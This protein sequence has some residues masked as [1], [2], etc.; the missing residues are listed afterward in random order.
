MANFIYVT[1]TE[2]YGKLKKLLDMNVK[3]GTDIKAQYFCIYAKS[4]I[5]ALKIYS[6]WFVN[7][8]NWGITDVEVLYKLGI[9]AITP[10][11][12]AMKE[13]KTSLKQQRLQY[14]TLWPE[15]SNKLNKV[16]KSGYNAGTLYARPGFYKQKVWHYDLNAAFAEAFLKA[17]IPVGIPEIIKG[18]VKPDGKHLHV[19][20][21]D[22]N[23]EYNS[24]TIFPYLVNSGDIN[25]VPSQI[26]DNTGYQSLYKVITEVEFED[27]KKDYKVYSNCLY[28]I[29]FKKASEIIRREGSIFL[30]FV[31][32]MYMLRHSHEGEAKVVYKTVLASLAGKFAQAIDQLQVPTMV[33]EFGNIEYETLKKD[34]E[35]V[36]YLHPAISLFV[37]DYVR[38]KV[39]DTIKKFGYKKVVLVDT[40]GFVAL[41]E[42]P[43]ELSHELGG[44]KCKT[45]DNIIVNGK[46]SY[47]YTEKGN[48]HS[49]ISGLG[50]VFEDGLN[51]LD[52]DELVNL[53]KLKR[54]AP[55]IKKVSY[56]GQEKYISMN[57]QVGGNDEL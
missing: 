43:I 49:S 32:G 27:L 8:D 9:K 22:L 1:P 23:V 2:L 28:T 51:K 29:R 6:T 3:F 18:Y 21:M 35:D 5:L 47:F 46:R 34:P 16:I 56:N 24:H 26:I 25:K 53:S 17:D 10:G 57:I 44:W 7:I 30:P 19:Y 4:R 36:Q 48:L 12:Y 31:N 38:K 54:T 14:D 33:N 13:F 11:A 45:Y 50:D 55:L 20:F 15:L 42:L 40:D 39:R 52:Y 41:E 37:V